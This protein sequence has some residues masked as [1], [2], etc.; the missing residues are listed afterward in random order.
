MLGVIRIAGGE[1][2]ASSANIARNA[3]LTAPNIVLATPAKYTKFSIRKVQ[4]AQ[5]QCW[6]SL[7]ERCTFLD[8]SS[9]RLETPILHYRTSSQ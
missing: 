3:T 8:R 1:V 2:E 6:S 9:Y 7:S 5:M 4:R